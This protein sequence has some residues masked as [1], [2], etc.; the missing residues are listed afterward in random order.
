[1]AHR[2]DATVDANEESAL[3]PVCDRV[4]CEP[5][6]VQLLAGDVPALSLGDRSDQ[7]LCRVLTAIAVIR[8]LGHAP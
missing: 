8:V 6:T 2:V 4:I 3:D 5:E 7:G 1:V